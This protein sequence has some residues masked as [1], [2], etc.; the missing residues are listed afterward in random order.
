MIKQNIERGLKKPDKTIRKLIQYSGNLI[1]AIIQ[2]TSIFLIGVDGCKNYTV[3]SEADHPRPCSRLSVFGGERKKRASE[4]TKRVARPQLPRAWNRL[5]PWKQS[6]E[7][8][9]R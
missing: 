7:R 1:L 6:E 3:L 5:R 2:L 9:L 8:L 4:E